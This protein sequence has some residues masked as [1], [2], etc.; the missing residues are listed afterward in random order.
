MKVE[1]FASGEPGKCA[2]AWN[3]FTVIKLRHQQ[4]LSVSSAVYICYESWV[5]SDSLYDEISCW[6]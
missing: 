4:C 1:G 3:F 5:F 2:A 6:C